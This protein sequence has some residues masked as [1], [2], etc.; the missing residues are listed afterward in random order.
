MINEAVCEGCGDCSVQSNCISIEPLE[1]ELGRKRRINQSSCNKDYSCVKGYCPSFVSVLGGRVRKA[2]GEGV[3]AADALFASLPEPEPAPCE[4]PCNVLIAGIGG[5]GVV[6]VGAILAVAAHLEGKGCSELDVTGLAQK[7]GPVSSHVRIARRP[8]AIFASRIG[9]GAADLV[10]GC[11]LV[12]A[13]NP[14]NLPRLTK[15][16]F[17][18]RHEPRCRAHRG[19]RAQQLTSISRASAWSRRCARPAATRTRASRMR[20]SSRACC[21]ATRSPR[22]CCCS[23]SPSSSGSCRSA[24]PRSS[25]PSS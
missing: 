18:F 17:L 11:D 7:N 16:T 10:I 19:L 2:S 14:E 15:G 21:S 4:E 12:V 8:E 5:S 23:A 3:A 22:T 25:A 6:T 9:V 20:R 13:T 24:S 1:T